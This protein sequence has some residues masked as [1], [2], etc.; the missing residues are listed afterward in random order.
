MRFICDSTQLSEAMATVSKALA[1]KSVMPVLEGVLA[2]ASGSGVSFCCTDLKMGIETV[3]PA[4]IAEEGEVVL[5]GRLFYEITRRLPE[6][7]VEIAVTTEGENAG[8]VITAPGL[9]TRLFIMD[10]AD[11][12]ALPVVENAQRIVLPGKSLRDLIRQTA[13][14]AS[15]DESRP[16]LTGVLLEINAGRVRFVALDGYRL[17][18]CDAPY[19]GEVQGMKAV[20]PASTLTR[21]AGIVGDSGNVALEIGP[22]HVG[23]DV[24][25]TRLVSRLLEGEF[26]RYEQIIPQDY[27]TRA[28][29]DQAAM[30]DALD[31]AAMLA[32][33]GHS[34]LVRLR[35][36]DAKLYMTSNS[37]SGDMYEEVPIQL[38]GKDLEIAFNARYLVDIFKNIGAGTVVMSFTTNVSP[39][40]LRPEAS[41]NTYLVLPVRVY[42]A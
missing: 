22:S 23:V 25:N 5:Q 4:Q 30:A 9:R 3:I 19:D 8:A 13:F 15:L 27:T 33:D 1:S 41:S 24:D 40:I 2:R 28:I 42:G 39:C 6:G 21:L 26:I 10:A 36:A 37:E 11:F 7:N 14:A 18:M 20:I 34:N 32:R 29:V 38:E 35:L 31:R 17:A 12:P 16:I